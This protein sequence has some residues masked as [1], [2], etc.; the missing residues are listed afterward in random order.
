MTPLHDLATINVPCEIDQ[1][2]ARRNILA[3]QRVQILRR[4]PIPDEGHPSFEPGLQR[5]LVWLEVHDGNFFRID[6]DVL[7]QN[8][9]RAPCNGA[10]TDEQDSIWESEHL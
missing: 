8:G 6:P 3:Q 1:E 9:H 5:C 7:E 10:K 2:I 4:D